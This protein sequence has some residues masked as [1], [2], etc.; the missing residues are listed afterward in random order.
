MDIRVFENL[1]HDLA[2]ALRTMRKSPAFSVA[3]VCT[4]ALGIGGNTA[5]FTVIRTVL[6]KPL[7]YRDPDRLVYLSTA[8]PQRNIEDGNIQ[9][10][11]IEELRAASKSFTAVGAYGANLENITLSGDAEPEALRGARV[12]ANFLDILGVQPVLGR[13]FRPDEDASGGPPVV[14]I[15]S[16]LW[17]RRF[18]GDP[19]VIGKTATLDST[20]HTIVGVLPPGFEFPFRGV[21]IWFA[22]PSEWSALP[23]RFWRIALLKGF[24]RLKPNV[25]LE[26][27]R[28]EMDVLSQ[29]YLRAHPG[30]DLGMIRAVWLKDRLVQNVRLMLWMLFGAM[31]FVLL[32][33][34]ANVASLMLARATSR[35]REFAVRAALGAARGRLIHQ[36]LAESLL[37]SVAGAVLGT[38]FAK[39]SLR[40][41]QTLDVLHIPGAGTIRLDSMVLAFTVTLSIATG[42]LFGLI[43]SLQVSQPNLADVLRET[44]A[45]AGQASSGRRS[46]LG[47]SPRAL[48]VV[49]QIALSIVLL[50]GAALLM[51]SFVRVQSVHP[52]FQ[53]ANL[54]TMKIA[55]P[56]VRYNTDPKK[57]AFF[58]GL[59]Q[60]VEAIPGV[61]TATVAMSL[62][63][64][65]WIRTNITEIQGRPAPDPRD[66]VFA[67]IE[68]VTPGYFGTL[69][70]PVRRGRE[71]TA[72]DNTPG[73]PP[74]II[75][76]ESLARRLWPDYPR[77]ID[78]IGQHIGEGYD[79]SIPW[80]EVVGI[81]A[82]IHEGGLA[83][84][85][86]PEFYIPCALHP[87]QS[88]YL[89]VRTVADPLSVV[90]SVRR[91]VLATDP[92]QSV[93]EVRTMES[94]LDAT[95]GQ[96]R[97]T[98]L[99]LGSFAGIALLL[100]MIGIY[101]VIAYSVA[102][103]TQEV[104]IR[105]ALGAQQSDILKL[106]LRQGLY[107]AL[108]GI[109]I[110]IGGAFA[111]TRTMKTQL[112]QV[113]AT[114]PA[115]FA[116]IAVLFVVV[117]LAASFIPAVRASRIDP[118][119]ALRIG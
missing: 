33:A 109:A 81:T 47:V 51:Q 73:A 117:A 70:I 87:P 115:T 17:K 45:A 16:D 15:G 37:L 10:P 43:P 83:S 36:L 50:I 12:S 7:E 54:L 77:G 104:G 39:W 28:A 100:A 64:T 108:A 3:A 40:V 8:N 69:R 80:F 26:Q 35:S 32:I 107:L 48:L 96:R 11:R 98:M 90:A 106:V 42:V 114:D 14:M 9:L 4:L 29:A 58:A 84:D 30:P 94:I 57:S 112:F 62:P 6:L 76:N 25:S 111:L 88:A 119:T 27:A 71:F 2:Y 23:S 38:S 79:K 46:A 78:P 85:A 93:S 24:G 49:G 21:D 61:R 110:G 31:G 92:D 34:C 22:R 56:P 82:D 118:M 95:L 41:F 72:H 91:Q 59:V 101:G 102:Q 53:P 66:P 86:V 103:R 13:G 52:G 105:R 67:V 5:M 68:S 65:T 60:R 99:L 63:T 1:R 97:L 89:A 18:A 116:I 74:A 19:A 75:V 44:G 20:P 113:D 55:L